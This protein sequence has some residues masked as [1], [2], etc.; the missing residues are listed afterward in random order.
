MASADEL[1]IDVWGPG[2]HAAMPEKTVDSIK[3]SSQLILALKEIVDKS[4]NGIR[5]V[6]TFGKIEGKG[7]TNVIPKHVHIEGTFRTL[8]EKWRK[9]VHEQMRSVTR[10][11]SNKSGARIELDIQKGYP[12]LVNDEK[13]TGMMKQLA[14]DYLGAGNVVDLELRMTSEDFAFYTQRY[15]SCFYRLGI[16]TPDKAITNL[17]SADFV[18]DE[19]ALKTGSGFMVYLAMKLLVG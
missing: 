17:H 2:G 3:V 15:K 5:T 9:E 18:V 12:C 16:R 1:Y 6:M 14:G 19:E 4:K 8:D 11:I 13:I 10:V 7:A